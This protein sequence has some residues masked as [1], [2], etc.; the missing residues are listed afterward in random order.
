MGWIFQK[1]LMTGDAPPGSW[2]HASAVLHSLAI[3]LS[4]L[5]GSGAVRCGA[6]AMAADA[7]RPNFIVVLTDD[8]RH[9]HLGV[10]GHPVLQTPHIDR[11]AEEG[12][13]FRNAYVVDSIC[14]VSRA[15]ILSGCY[16][17][18]H[19]IQVLDTAFEPAAFAETYPA[20]L[21]QAGYRVGH[22]GK[23]HLGV[24]DGGNATLFDD[25]RGWDGYGVHYQQTDAS[26]QPI[27][28]TRRHGDDAVAL[29]KA[30]AKADQP[31][32]LNLW[33]LAP[34]NE[35]YNPATSD[36]ADGYM[37][38]P[39]F[40]ELFSD[41]VPDRVPAYGE[42]YRAIPQVLRHKNELHKRF[43]KR[44]ADEDVRTRVIRNYCRLIAGVDEVVGR[45]TAELESSG[46][47]ENTVIVFLSDNGYF[48]GEHGLG[49]KFWPHEPS[50]RV[51]MIW[52]DPRLPQNQRGTVRDEVALNIDVAPTL[53]DYAG[54]D[55][56]V[57]S[58]NQGR[59]L[60]P[61]VEGENAEDWRTDF[62]YQHLYQAYGRGAVPRIP[63]CEGV[64]GGTMKYFRFLRAEHNRE[65]EGEPPLTEH[66]YD[67]SQDPHEQQNLAGRVEYLQELQRLRKRCANLKAAAGK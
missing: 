29:L 11:L 57:D 26:G 12:T 21:Q 31:F 17:E 47:A 1:Q 13:R 51:P 37:P 66:L 64:V 24:A 19:G 23:W 40:A 44:Y 22:V 52:Y 33:F 55:W 9:D 62:Y 60:R 43:D 15:S 7:R 6:L 10:A 41:W 3:L 34:H 58:E 38:D 4:F 61:I 39:A 54:V 56:P 20:L 28:L 49:G 30:Y 67:L 42:Y 14:S 8:Q 59:S 45:L 18:R 53:L 46:L 50:V 35:A 27:H 48:Q 65:I 16:P 63:A 36:A 5:T 32:C 25:W 2:P